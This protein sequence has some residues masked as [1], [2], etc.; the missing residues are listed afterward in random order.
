[1]KLALGLPQQEVPCVTA[2]KAVTRETVWCWTCGKGEN[3]HSVGT[4]ILDSE[5][6]QEK[7]MLKRGA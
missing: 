7:R 2:T 4:F 6:L 5:K 1:M 3:E